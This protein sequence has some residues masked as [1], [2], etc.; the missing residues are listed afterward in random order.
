MANDNNITFTSEIKRVFKTVWNFNRQRDIVKKH[1]DLTFAWL[2]IKNEEEDFN[3]FYT[4]TTFKWNWHN[5]LYQYK[6]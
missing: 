1:N 5:N 2:S 4:I 3:S 6:D